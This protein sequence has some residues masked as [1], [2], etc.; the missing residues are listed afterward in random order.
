MRT[1]T[2]VNPGSQEQIFVSSFQTC[3]PPV[4]AAA[5]R[6]LQPVGQAHASMPLRHVLRRNV[7][8]HVKKKPSLRY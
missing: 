1:E 7:M 3:Y 6:I 5:A 8:L 4:W 2:M